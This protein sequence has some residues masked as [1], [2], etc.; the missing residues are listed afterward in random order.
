MPGNSTFRNEEA[1]FAACMFTCCYGQIPEGLGVDDFTHAECR[2]IISDAL[3]LKAQGKAVSSAALQ[4]PPKLLEAF[5]ARNYVSI[6]PEEVAGLLRECTHRRKLV[7]AIFGTDVPPNNN[8]VEGKFADGE[9]WA[10]AESMGTATLVQMAAKKSAEIKAPAKVYDDLVESYVPT[11][12][13]KPI[14]WATL[15]TEDT[16]LAA[17]GTTI[18]Y[19][20]DEI[21]PKHR[22]TMLFGQ[23]KSCKSIISYD[24]VKHVANG[25]TWLNRKVVKTPCLYI[26]LEDGIVGAYIGWL[27]NVGKEKVRFITLRSKNGIPQLD[28]PS[29]LALC[30][31]KQP[32]IVLDSLHKLFGRNKEGK[33][34]SAFTSSDYEPVLE[35][36][37]QLCVAGAT[38]ILI[39]HST[40]ADQEQ[41][42]DSSAIGA[43]VDFMFAVVAEAPDAKGLKRVA[44]KGQPS[45]G[46]QPPTIH[47][48]AFPHIIDHGHLCVDA[49]M[50]KEESAA[51]EAVSEVRKNGPVDSRTKLWRRIGGTKADKMA[52]IKE[53]IDKGWLHENEETG[54]INLGSNPV[55]SPVPGRV[56]MPPD[57]FRTDGGTD[58]F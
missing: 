30:A 38:V 11:L 12:A 1:E 14:E 40:K 9:K 39:H 5:E 53:A 23:E 8:G 29:L 18:E 37:R 36:I 50:E 49:G 43:N 56:P 55:L 58:E 22:V 42:R 25:V 57:P 48:L 19:I 28:D 41:Y 16:I 27:Q 52:A 35:K 21:I 31:E 6:Q 34:G 17:Q 24:L 33:F 7:D 45:R 2:T 54:Q 46:A 4:V 32:L 26:D 10:K 51:E 20:V 3:Q 13:A 44:L 47:I 15:D